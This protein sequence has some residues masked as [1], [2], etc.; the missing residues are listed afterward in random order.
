MNQQRNH[1]MQCIVGCKQTPD[2]GVKKC[3]YGWDGD[4]FSEIIELSS[5][6]IASVD[7]IDGIKVLGRGELQ[8]AVE[9]VSHIL[10]VCFLVL[11][12]LTFT[13][14]AGSTEGVQEIYKLK[15]GGT[16]QFRKL[17]TTS[18]GMRLCVSG[19]IQITIYS[20]SL[21]IV[22]QYA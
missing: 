19:S 5:S 7:D 21:F 20:I 3:V 9:S 14:L 18:Q 15:S 11:Q 22:F 13:S 12:D 10:N 2:N 8:D 17:G 6:P 1:N 16:R 4:T